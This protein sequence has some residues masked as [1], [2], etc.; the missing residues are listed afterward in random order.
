MFDKIY[1]FG[2]GGG[3]SHLIPVLAKT[4]RANKST[5]YSPLIIFD[6]DDFEEKNMERQLLTTT[7][8][9]QNKA[10]SLLET[11]QAQGISEVYSVPEYVDYQKCI[12]LLEDSNSPLV[13]AAVDNN[14][15]RAAFIDAI[16]KVCIEDQQKNFF[17]ITPGNSDATEEPRG[18]ICW[19]G[20]INGQ[21]YGQN[22]KEYDLDLQAPGDVIP[23]VGGCMEV[24]QSNPQVLAANFTAAADT[25]TVIYSVLT[26]KLDPRLSQ[27]RFNCVKL[28]STIS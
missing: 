26:Q 10:Q 20:H 14:A 4:L 27:K 3:G 2:A 7:Q 12:E 15:S 6:G 25:L 21:K 13:I 17:F 8:I 19:F 5:K 9:K 1:V 24:A 22:P 28:T 18:Q 16:Q 11:C 23:R